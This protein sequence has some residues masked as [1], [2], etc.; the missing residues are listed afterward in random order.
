MRSMLYYRT[1]TWEMKKVIKNAENGRKLEDCVKE[2]SEFTRG[3]IKR[4][5][6]YTISAL[7]LGAYYNSL[8]SAGAGVFVGGISI[9]TENELSRNA[10][11]VLSAIFFAHSILN[12]V[13]THTILR[14]K[15]ESIFE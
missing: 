11:F 4:G 10:A 3:A 15:V 5:K 2:T 6:N 12:I 14:K 7:E 13:Y 8:M 1:I 9:Y